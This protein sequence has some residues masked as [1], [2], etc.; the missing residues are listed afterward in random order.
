MWN[1]PGPLLFYALAIPYRLFGSNSRSILLGGTALNAISVGAVAYLLLATRTRGRPRA[2]PHRHVRARQCA[3]AAARLLF[4]WNPFVIVLP[5]LVLV[6]LTW[7]VA[8]GDHWMLPFA[9]G[10]ASF[11]MA[12]HVGSAAPAF[13]LLAIALAS[14]VVD[15]VRGRVE[16][17]RASDRVVGRCRVLRVGAADHRTVPARRRQPRDAV[18]LLHRAG[19]IRPS[20]SPT[21][22][23]CSRRSCRSPPPGSP[24][25]S[26]LSPFNW[27][28]RRR[29]AVPDRA[30]R[31]RCRHRRCRP[32]ARPRRVQ[33]RRDRA[34][35]RRRRL[36]RHRQ[37]RRRA[38]PVSPQVDVGSRGGVVVRD[39][40]DHD[41][42]RARSLVGAATPRRARRGNGSDRAL[43][44]AHNDQF[45]ARRFS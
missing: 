36:A 27:R 8:C 35:A 29:L 18:G 37:H 32:P 34:R 33:H 40:L 13:A 26:A 1:H 11:V 22:R 2:R 15:A 19:T 38:V 39:R 5:L 6:F 9:M 12:S 10:V 20:G 23:A 42:R 45:G 7:S 43:G 28:A 31:A 41:P 30:D 21:A 16:A 17:T 24:A 44:R 25:T 3:R 14:F 4:P